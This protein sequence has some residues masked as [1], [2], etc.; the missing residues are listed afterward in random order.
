VTSKRHPARLHVL[1]ARDAPLALVIRRGPAKRVST[2]AWYRDKGNVALGQWMNGRIYERRCDLAPDGKH[3]IYFAMNGHWQGEAGGSWTAI[4]RAP[5]LKA[6]TLLAKGDCWQGGGLFLDE[7]RVWVNGL[8]CHTPLRDNG[9]VKLD[10]DYVPSAWYGGECLTVYYNRLQRDGWILTS[11]RTQRD[12]QLL[13][14]FEK[15][16]PKGWT[17]QKI[18]NVS[19]SD[20]RPRGTGVY[21]DEHA[22]ENDEGAFF[23][24]PKWEWADWVDGNL[25]YA[26]HGC[27]YRISILRWDKLGAPGL[28]H[29]FNPYTFE[30]R[31]APY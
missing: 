19:T 23:P 22:L 2:F 4:A 18:C 3:W 7:R 30:A 11:L 8:G 9:E 25:V 24:F 15:A 17:L 27:L 6:T 16:L 26:E 10:P 13:T 20:K 12:P 14:V 5:W 21:W 1:L 28:I 29:D 31:P